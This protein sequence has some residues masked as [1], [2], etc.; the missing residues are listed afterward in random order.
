MI[1]SRRKAG[2]GT[3]KRRKRNGK[4][5]ALG[6]AFPETEKGKEFATSWNKI[7]TFGYIHRAET[8]YQ[9]LV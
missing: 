8:Y 2:I 7:R 6:A 3:I 5:G 1:R 9:T 4:Q